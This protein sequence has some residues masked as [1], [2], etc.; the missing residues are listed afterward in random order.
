LDI[1]QHFLAYNPDTWDND[2]DYIV[3]QQ[4]LR[5]LKVVSETERGVTL[6]WSFSGVLTNQEEQEQ[7]L[8]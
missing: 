2:N 1:P 5:S 6:I 4:T 3:A 8:L 7:F